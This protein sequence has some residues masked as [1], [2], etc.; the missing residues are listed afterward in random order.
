MNIIYKISILFVFFIIIGLHAFNIKEGATG[1]GPTG[2]VGETG[3]TGPVGPQ[4]ATGAVGPQGANGL[5]GSRGLNGI[6][7][8]MGPRGFN[9][10]QGTN[11]RNGTP[12][13]NGSTGRRGPQGEDGPIGPTG[14]IGPMGDTG[15][16]GPVGPHGPQSKI[17]LGI[18]SPIKTIDRILNS[19]KTH[20]YCLG[21][22]ITCPTGKLKTEADGYMGGKTYN[23]LCD[24][25]TTEAIC[26]HNIFTE[27]KYGEND[28]F[29]KDIGGISTAFNIK[30]GFSQQFD[31]IDQPFVYDQ[32]LNMIDFYHKGTYIDNIDICKFLNST[33]RASFCN[34]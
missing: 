7:G 18:D 1:E 16:T 31:S 5:N 14:P 19:N 25:N 24:D 3:P 33:N 10:I 8:P 13:M 27:L 20:S 9:G 15:A 28:T 34:K 22:N 21:G 4:G 26:A 17:I 32:S 12:G 6:Q 29:N 30:T 2:P 23:Y 11:G